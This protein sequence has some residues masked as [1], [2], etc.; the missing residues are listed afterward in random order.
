MRTNLLRVF[1]VAGMFSTTTVI[2]QTEVVRDQIYPQD[3]I[4]LNGTLF[5]QPLN[6]VGDQ[7]WKSD[8]TYSGT[9]MLKDL[10]PGTTDHTFGNQFIFQGKLYFIAGY[11][12]QD[13]ALWKSDGTEVGTEI[14]IQPFY[15][16]D[17]IITNDYFYFTGAGGVTKSDGTAAGTTVITKNSLPVR[18]TRLTLSNNKLF[19]TSQDF[20]ELWVTD[21]TDAG[22]Q[23]VKLI[24]TGSDTPYGIEK[25]TDS[26]GV[27]YF[28]A[29]DG[30]YGNTKKGVELW[31]SDG[32]DAGTYMV[33]DINPGMGS[34]KSS[35][36]YANVMIAYNGNIYFN[37]TD[38]TH[39]GLW[40]SDGTDAGTVLVKEGISL[41][42]KHAITNNK[43]FFRGSDRHLWITNGTNEGTVLLDSA[44]ISNL[45]SENIVGY[46]GI[47]YY[48]A[49][50]TDQQLNEDELW[51]SDGTPAGT[52]IV[53]NIG[54]YSSAGD[55]HDL[56]IVD[57]YLYFG[58]RKDFAL[59]RLKMGTGGSTGISDINKTDFSIYPNPAGNLVTLSKLPNNTFVNIT[60][61]A[62][63][64]VY[65]A[66]TNTKELYINTSGFS[67]GVYLVQIANNGAVATKKLI[68]N[69]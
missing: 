22:T 67:N 24:V 4:N 62:G 48:P 3:L 18:G 60:D 42:P 32:T 35:D 45:V 13:K 27:I 65:S 11:S 38:G 47:V 37:A 20:K 53:E 26:N 40:K 31:R 1:I 14:V 52:F 5:F 68:V 12:S 30:Q 34:S 44:E 61:L 55:P 41:T 63:K 59:R 66:I 17:L 15:M 56:A 25:M 50:D 58:V 9:A 33:K 64:H 7:L 29:A 51:Q 36:V 39:E 23:L 2:A 28:F 21:G 19:Y 16:S 54:S 6:I 46:N 43:F 49:A 57:D 10:Y 69:K 8:G